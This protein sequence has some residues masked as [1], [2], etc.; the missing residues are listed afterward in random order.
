M[1]HKTV[2]FLVFP[3]ADELTR[4]NLTCTN[5]KARELCSLC[6]DQFSQGKAR[7]QRNEFCYCEGMPLVGIQNNAQ[8]K[9]GVY[10]EDTVFV[11]KHYQV[12]NREE[13]EI[14]TLDDVNNTFN[15]CNKRN[16]KMFENVEIDNVYNMM[17]LFFAMT[18]DA[19]QSSQIATPFTI[20]ELNH[21]RFSIEL[22]NV[23]M[24]RST[25]LEC[26]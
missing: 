12:H 8:L 17:M 23:A 22:A 4:M 21:P 20:H 11:P 13:Y 1:F 26:I 2:N 3:V 25:K 19:S 9:G 18:I 6:S 15:L 14:V 24:S 5:A 7:I 16:G 10:N